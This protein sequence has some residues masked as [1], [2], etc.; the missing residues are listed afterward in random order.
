ME[1]RYENRNGTGEKAR[2]VLSVQELKGVLK[3]VPASGGGLQHDYK[4]QISIGD[5]GQ[6]GVAVDVDYK[7]KIIHAFLP[8]DEVTCRT[9]ISFRTPICELAIAYAHT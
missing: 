2:V 3:G 6:R 7:K 5:H 9:E 8:P 1:I 4:L